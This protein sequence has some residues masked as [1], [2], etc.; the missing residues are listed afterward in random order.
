MAFFRGAY[1]VLGV[2]KRGFLGVIFRVFTSDIT[3]MSALLDKGVY[4]NSRMTLTRGSSIE[5]LQ[6]LLDILW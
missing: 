4:N 1:K 5:G 6:S 2:T 3:S